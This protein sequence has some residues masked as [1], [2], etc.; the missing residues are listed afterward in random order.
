MSAHGNQVTTQ[1]ECELFRK[2]KSQTKSNARRQGKKKNSRSEQKMSF[3]C[4]EKRKNWCCW[5]RESSSPNPTLRPSTFFNPNAWYRNHRDVT[6]IS[7]QSSQR[8]HETPK[9]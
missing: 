5:K 8:N 2:R 9:G 7:N 6:E 4:K 1:R 3:G